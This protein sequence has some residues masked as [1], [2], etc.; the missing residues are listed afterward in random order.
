MVK[1][2]Y[3]YRSAIIHGSTKVSKKREI[4]LE[5][6]SGKIETVEL[7]NN[8]L[9]EILNILLNNPRFLDPSVIDREMIQR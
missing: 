1:K 8:Y 2:I 4:E 9:R 7:A 3:D 6:Q 5:H